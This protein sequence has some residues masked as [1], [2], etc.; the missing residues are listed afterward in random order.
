MVLGIENIEVKV[1]KH[2]VL[3]LNLVFILAF[4]LFFDSISAFS[5]QIP[6]V[7]EDA[8]KVITYQAQAA[9]GYEYAA[10][11]AVLDRP[12]SVAA[13]TCFANAGTAMADVAGEIFSGKVS[14][15]ANDVLTNSLESHF[16]NFSWDDIVSYDTELK[17]DASFSVDLKISLGPDK[18]PTVKNVECATLGTLWAKKEAKPTVSLPTISDAINAIAK[19]EDVAETEA[20]KGQTAYSNDSGETETPGKKFIAEWSASDA[21]EAAVKINA[22][23][24]TLRNRYRD[25]DRSFS[26]ETDPCET[27]KSMS[28]SGF[29]CNDFK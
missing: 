16:K 28:G 18:G 13:V 23:G 24:S 12:S 25:M 7:D 22:E 17:V 11:N 3:K 26:D 20:S 15:E 6:G 4:C 5:A 21:K 2:L 1:N 14:K 9:V 27:L 29:N 19:G 10:S 8:K